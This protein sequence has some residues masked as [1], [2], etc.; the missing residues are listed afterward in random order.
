MKT[1]TATPARPLRLIR[2]TPMQMHAYAQA[3]ALRG[4]SAMKGVA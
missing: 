4:K 2:L 1:N 3:M